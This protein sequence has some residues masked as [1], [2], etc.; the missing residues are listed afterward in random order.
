MG[1]SIGLRSLKRLIISTLIVL[2]PIFSV[3]GKSLGNIDYNAFMYKNEDTKIPTTDFSTDDK[4]VV[5]IIFKNLPTGD[6]T[7]HADWHNALGD[8]QDTSRYRFTIQKKTEEIV[9]SQLEI[10]KASPLR[11]LFSASEATGYHIKF[12][13]KWQVK[14]YLNGKEIIRKHFTVR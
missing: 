6:Y 14:L 3:W 2:A 11:R 7:F 4:I 10:M 5:R 12:Y 13:G 9:E 8:L 1:N